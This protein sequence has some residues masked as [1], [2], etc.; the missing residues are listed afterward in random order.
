[1]SKDFF[2]KNNEKLNSFQREISV[3]ITGYIAEELDDLVSTLDIELRKSA[4]DYYVRG[5]EDYLN[6]PDEAAFV[7][8]EDLGWSEP[9][10]KPV[11][12]KTIVDRIIENCQ[13][14][15]VNEHDKEISD[16]LEAYA[17]ILD[18]M[19]KEIRAAKI[20]AESD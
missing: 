13:Q 9:F 16:E 4:R 10:I 1:M 6:T 3:D 11:F 20:T 19:A 12:C 8:H 14:Y 17:Q 7:I 15:G 5:T 2:S 18:A